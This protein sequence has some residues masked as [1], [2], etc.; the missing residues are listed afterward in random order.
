MFVLLKASVRCLFILGYLPVFN[1][2]V[3][4]DSQEAVGL[5]L[6]DLEQWFF[7]LGGEWERTEEKG[8]FCN[9]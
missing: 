6:V 9:I 4:R 1:S 5:E 7:K 8:R 3:L 2:E